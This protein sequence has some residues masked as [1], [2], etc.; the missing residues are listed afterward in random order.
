VRSAELTK[1]AAN[2]MRT[3]TRIS[4]MNELAN[5]SGASARTRVRRASDRTPRFH[6]CTRRGLRGS[7]FP[8]DVKALIRTAEEAGGVLPILE[9]V[10]E[11]NAAQKKV[12][13]RKILARFGGKLSGRRIAVWGLA[14]KQNTD[15]MRE[16]SSQVL[17]EELVANGASVT[18]RW[19]ARGKRLLAA[20]S[21]RRYAGPP[22]AALDG[23]DALAIV[24]EWQEFRSPD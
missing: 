4:F 20:R 7:C 14:F 16:A 19:R 13:A 9:A 18:A 2:A 11:V 8:K 6:F 12:L 17:I 10:D 21:R 5:L 1:Y 24:T 22:L 3:A 23:A 15:D